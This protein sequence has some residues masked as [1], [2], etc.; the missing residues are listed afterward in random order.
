MNKYAPEANPKRESVVLIDPIAGA[1][2]EVLQRY[3]QKHG[4]GFKAWTLDSMTG[5]HTEQYSPNQ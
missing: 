4:M 3:A 2:T 5:T 1:V